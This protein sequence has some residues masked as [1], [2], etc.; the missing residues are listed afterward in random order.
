[1]QQLEPLQQQRRHS[2]ELEQQLVLVLE[3]HCNHMVP[4]LEQVPHNMVLELEQV[5]HN[6]ALEP[7]LGS[8]G[9]SF[10]DQ[11]DDQRK[12]EPKPFR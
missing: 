2:K 10:G 9:Y 3:Q 6:M 1:M 12:V 4:E 11:E 5:P 8:I 7:V